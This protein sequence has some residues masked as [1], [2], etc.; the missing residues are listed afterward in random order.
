MKTV[1]CDIIGVLEEL[2]R[3]MYESSKKILN[4]KD[5]K[6]REEIAIFNEGLLTALK[7]VEECKSAFDAYIQEEN[8]KAKEKENDET[9]KE[10]DYELE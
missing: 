3:R 4:A 6:K 9:D 10:D 1:N 7:I 8:E 2:E 5:V